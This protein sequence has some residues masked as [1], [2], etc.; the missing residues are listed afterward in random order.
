MSFKQQ[1][2]W[3]DKRREHKRKENRRRKMRGKKK[4]SGER[5]EE[6]TYRK[7]QMSVTNCPLS[8]MKQ[9]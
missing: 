3:V 8:I 1:W 2:I 7:H 4:L 6:Y 9:G 5:R